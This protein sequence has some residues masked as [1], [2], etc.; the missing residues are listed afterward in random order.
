V[1]LHEDLQKITHKYHN[2]A[3]EIRGCHNSA[4][5]EP[6]FLAYDVVHIDI[7]V[8]KFRW[9]FL[10]PCSVYHQPTTGQYANYARPFILRVEPSLKLKIKF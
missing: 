6:R 1:T 7:L 8:P 2:C 4:E 3:S 9:S 5:E 10:P